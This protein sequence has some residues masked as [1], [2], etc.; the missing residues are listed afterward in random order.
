MLHLFTAICGKKFKIKILILKLSIKNYVL[1]ESLSINFDRGFSV[2]T[3]ETGAGKSVLLAALNLLLGTRVDHKIVGSSLKK[4]IIEGE[5]QVD[6]NTHIDF[7]HSNDL[8]FDE[9]SIIRREI[10]SN[11]KSRAFI[12]DSPVKLEVLKTFSN[13]LINVHT[14]N[15]SHILS[16]TDLFYNL[17]DTYSD[18]I[19][20]IKIFKKLLFEYNILKKQLNLVSKERDSFM[21]NLEYNRFIFNEIDKMSLVNDDEK[22]E[23]EAMFQ[24]MKNFDKI[25]GLLNEFKILS[26]IEDE[27]I[28]DRLNKISNTI[29]KISSYSNDFKSLS[30]R[31]ENLNHEIDDL[32]ISVNDYLNNLSFDHI[33]FENIQRRL[34]KINELEKKYNV[35]SISELI[36]KKNEIKKLLDNTDFHN[37]KIKQLEKQL[38][39][40]RRDILKISKNISKARKIS[41]LKVKFDLEK[42]FKDLALK[43]SMIEFN[44]TES[45]E[46]NKNGINNIDILYRPSKQSQSNKLSKI[47]SG[48]EKSR[49]LF[50]IISI[51]AKKIHLPTLVFDE[52]DSGTSGEISNSIGKMMKDIGDKMQII[53]VTH[54]PQV[55]SLA[56]HHFKVFKTQ[57]KKNMITSVKKLDDFSRVEEIAS[58]ISGDNITKSA[59][60][61]ASELLK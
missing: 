32:F 11:G 46:F 1:I 13:K 23:L 61:Q 60:K 17:L 4:C 3:G 56:N 51:L 37:E 48:G 14:Q 57:D 31:F 40:Q 16:D 38:E 39:I 24:H 6:K 8:D 18:Q 45:D 50:A 12:N 47:A 34:F 52:I 2:I 7:F 5:F 9:I 53:A 22:T 49:I 55:A 33:E 26:N 20:I 10:L 35:S 41:A 36:N 43:D 54:L 15:Q 44:I 19:S 29:K 27:N 58:M 28:S 21:N 30:E 25:S 59:I 42:V